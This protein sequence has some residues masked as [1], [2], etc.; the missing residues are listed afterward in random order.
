MKFSATTTLVCWAPK[1]LVDSASFQ[2]QI[3][4][5]N[6]ET[7]LVRLNDIATTNGGNRAFGYAGYD[8]SVD[9][10][11]SRISAVE[12]AK[13]WKQDFSAVF[14]S[15]LRANLTVNGEKLVIYGLSGSTFTPAAGITAELVAGPEG[16]AACEAASYADLDVNGKIVLVREALC[17][18]YRDGYHAGVMKP[19]AA[20]GAEAVVVIN[21]FYLNLTA[22]TLGPADDGT[23]VPTGFVNKYIGDPLKARLDA[24]ETLTATFWE[25]QFVDSRVTQNVFAETE[26]GDENNVIV[27]SNSVTNDL[28]SL[29]R[30]VKLG[31]HLDSVAWGAGINDNELFLAL[32]KYS[33]NNKI[34]FAWWGAEERGLIGSRYYV[35]NLNATESGSI[36]AYLNFDMVSKG[37][38][39]V[40]DGDGASYGVAAPPGSDVIQ[41]LFTAEFIAKGFNVTAARFTN[42][43]DYASFWQVLNKPI[44]GL[45][46]GTGSAQDPCYHLECDNINNPDL[47]QLTVNAK[48]TAHVLS[49]LALDGTNLI[50]KLDARGLPV[51]TVGNE[52]TIATVEEPSDEHH[53]C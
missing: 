26:G 8:A 18:G 49:A 32:T 20:A 13:V 35:N 19:A 33:T 48:T 7:N 46:T 38:Y 1:P 37:Y 10:I 53:H 15:E 16:V 6:L 9:Y 3:S 30:T 50:K 40:F 36:L 22:G 39:G 21:D 5:Q 2:E 25:D 31:A 51:R 17:P 52:R 27:V 4:K 42:G 12:G 34:R 28:D 11:W 47:D 24:G 41:E 44:G 23:Y 45:H 14:S 43:S 29:L